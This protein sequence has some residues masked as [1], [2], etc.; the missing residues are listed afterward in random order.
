M[1]VLRIPFIALIALAAVAATPGT[2]VAQSA[3]L[4]AT[5][6]RVEAEIIA[7]INAL[8]SKNG[9]SALRANSNL[10]RAAQGHACDNAARNSY[11]HTGSNGSGLAQRLERVGYNWRSAAENTG[12]GQKTPA[13]MMGFWTKSGGHL[14]NILQSDLRDAGVGL[15]RTSDG[16]NAWVL[17]MGR[18]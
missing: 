10:T 16:R 5:N 11:S 14:A 3:C 4:Q 1:P 17:V 7:S 13:A 6:A 8:R 18:R 15:A 12:L 9:L 2:S